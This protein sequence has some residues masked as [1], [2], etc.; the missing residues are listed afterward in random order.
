MISIHHE[1]DQAVTVEI[2]SNHEPL[3]FTARFTVKKF[4]LAAIAGDRWRMPFRAI[5]PILYCR[6][7]LSRVPQ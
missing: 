5:Y 2:S 1:N 4:R 7:R 6:Q 3:N